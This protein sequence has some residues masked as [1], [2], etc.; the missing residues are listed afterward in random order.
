MPQFIISLN[1]RTTNSKIAKFNSGN[2]KGNKNNSGLIIIYR[3]F[4][5]VA[6]FRTRQAKHDDTSERPVFLSQY[7]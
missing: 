7:R 3:V 2:N 1:I 5:G 6:D 4:V